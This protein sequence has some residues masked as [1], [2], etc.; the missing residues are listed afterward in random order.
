VAVGSLGDTS[1]VFLS[2]SG[3]ELPG[4][5][6]EGLEGLEMEAL[7]D[8]LLPTAVEAFNGGLEACFAGGHK[9]RDHAK[10]EAGAN[11]AADGVGI[12]MR[13]LKAGVVIELGIRRETNLRP[14]LE[15][16]FQGPRGS[17]SAWERPGGSESTMQ[18][19][20]R[21]DVA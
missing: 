18:G 16:T 11:D 10:L 5:T 13:A 9:D 21:E 2:V 15:D 8:G 1:G 20:G 12:L 17:R 4:L 3:D 14:A 7:P 6:N 19:N